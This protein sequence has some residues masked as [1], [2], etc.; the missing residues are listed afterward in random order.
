[1]IL[2]FS[3][4]EWVVP[5]VAEWIQ[6]VESDAGAGGESLIQALMQATTLCPYV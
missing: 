6:A 5:S 3:L 2:R 1:M 4:G